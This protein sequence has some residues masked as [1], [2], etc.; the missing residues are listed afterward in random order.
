[1]VAEGL[2]RE[3]DILTPEPIGWEALAR[4]HAAALLER[5]RTGTLSLRE[6]RGLGL[7]W[8]PAL[9]ERARRATAGTLAAAEEALDSASP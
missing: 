3:Q 2:V 8:S 1:V 7:P 9:I 4:V 5:L 6:E